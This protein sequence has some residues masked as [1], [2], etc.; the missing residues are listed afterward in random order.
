LAGSAALGLEFA[1][2]LAVPV[3]AGLLAG[4]ELSPD[5]S[6]DLPQAAVITVNATINKTSK[7]FLAILTTTFVKKLI[8]PDLNVYYP[9]GLV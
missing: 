2:P 7:G 1:L 5:F 8:L 9:T 3:A 6:F 4:G